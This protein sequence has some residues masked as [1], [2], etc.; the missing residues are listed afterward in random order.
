MNRNQPDK[1]PK[2]NEKQSRI[3]HVGDWGYYRPVTSWGYAR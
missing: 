3:R 2:E 1:N